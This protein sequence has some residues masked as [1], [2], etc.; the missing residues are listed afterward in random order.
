MVCEEVME[1][2][3]VYE[4]VKEC[5]VVCE[6]VTGCVMVYAEFTEFS[7]VCEE[8]TVCIS[9]Y[10]LVCNKTPERN[11]MFF[12]FF[13]LLERYSFQWPLEQILISPS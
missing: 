6:A 11:Q 4:E 12:C 5:A 3:I 10:A 7:M 2:A 8:V 9:N 13:V 1:C